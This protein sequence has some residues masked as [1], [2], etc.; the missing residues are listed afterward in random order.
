MTLCQ[1]IQRAFTSNIYS[2]TPYVYPGVQACTHFHLTPS[3][4]TRL[5]K[6]VTHSNGSQNPFFVFF[7][8]HNGLGEKTEKKEYQKNNFDMPL[9]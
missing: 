7:V 8:L 5:H 4:Y 3:M 2:Y 6:Y 1:G 9:Q